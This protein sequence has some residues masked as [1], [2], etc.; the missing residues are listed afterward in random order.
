MPQFIIS[1]IGGNALGQFDFA[2]E[3]VPEPSLA[4]LQATA[5]FTLA[6]KSRGVR[7]SNKDRLAQSQ[8]FIDQ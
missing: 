2:L 7:L 8:S 3:N 6:F 1:Y 4:L 5:L